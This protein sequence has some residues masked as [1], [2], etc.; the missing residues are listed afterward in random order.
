MS[1][2]EP[3]GVRLVLA[4][5]TIVPCVLLRCEELD[6]DGL[7]GW[8]GTPLV[9]LESPVVLLRADIMPARTELR[10]AV[11]EPGRPMRLI[12]EDSA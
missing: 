6:H 5:G 1:A 2:A 4:D 9:T 3:R 10:I 12:P 7:T 8:V 11:Q